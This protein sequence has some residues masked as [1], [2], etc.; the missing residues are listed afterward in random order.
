MPHLPTP[1]EKEV[2]ASK[3]DVPPVDPE[4]PT[5]LVQVLAETGS[6]ALRVNLLSVPDTNTFFS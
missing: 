1:A 6:L 4:K 2:C 3:L 5:G